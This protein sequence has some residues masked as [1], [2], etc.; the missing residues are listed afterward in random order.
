MVLTGTDLYRDIQGDAMAQRSLELADALVVLQDQAVHSLPPSIRDK[1][2]VIHP[3]TTSRR[4]L[5]KTRRHLRVV[6]AG[7]LRSEKSPQTLF[8]CAR[9]LLADTDILIDHVGGAL[10]AGLAEEAR[11]TMRDCPN[12]R[13]LGALPHEDVRRR[14]QRS[15]VL[16]HPSRMEG[17]AHVII[18]AL[19]CGTPVLASR[20][21][22]NV[23]M[24]GEDYRGYFALGD[25]RGLAHWLR[26]CRDDLHS[27]TPVPGLLQTLAR[28]CEARAPLFHPGVERQALQ[29]LCSSLIGPTARGC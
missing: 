23:G 19:C 14:I 12:Y 13:W 28:Q 15:H 29:H 6:M 5:A 16:V 25:S 22:G 21:A 17:A 11:A 26:L 1:A 3:S 20:V 27:N 9:E 7:H 18:E 24:L 10:E 2:R 8:E 4:T